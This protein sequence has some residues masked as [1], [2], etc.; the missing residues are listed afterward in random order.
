LN[1]YLVG[2]VPVVASVIASVNP[3]GVLRLHLYFSST[4]ILLWPMVFRQ[5]RQTPLMA[6]ISLGFMAITMG[7]FVMTTTTF[8]HLSPYMVN[9][10]LFHGGI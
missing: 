4:A 6:I 10:A 7:F 9:S 5:F 1:I 8:S 3:S 2:L